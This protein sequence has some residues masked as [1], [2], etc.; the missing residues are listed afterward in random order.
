MR[1]LLSAAF[2]TPQSAIIIAL[3]I[4][5]FGL[6]APLLGLPAAAWLVFGAVAEALYLGV[7]V[8]DPKAQQRA[9]RQMLMDRYNPASIRNP[10]AR[11]R[12]EKAMEYFAAMQ[13]MALTR[14]G[15]SRTEFENTINDVDDWI[16][17][18]HTLGK[19]IDSFDDNQI[20]NRDRMQARNDLEALNRRLQAEP[21][22]RVKEEIRRSI[23]IKKTQLENLENLEANIK[24]ADIQMD[25][26]L[27]ALGTVY[28]Q[29]Q[30]IGSKEIDRTSAQR[31]RN[32]IHEQVA[33]LQ[34]TI[35]SIDE[36]QQVNTLS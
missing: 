5:L 16:A 2:F 11:K 9:V 1:A 32:Q 25:N 17:E 34:D 13:K 14:S 7:T 15:A 3:C 29:M 35:S 10:G 20:I 26:T 27:A 31:L 24:R 6:Q 21:N 22:E 18:L 28:A 4:I 33:E 23:E 19:R 36:V 8:T 30:V 12:L